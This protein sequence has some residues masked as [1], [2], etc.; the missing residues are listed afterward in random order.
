MSDDVADKVAYKL[1]NGCV[2]NE[3][4]SPVIRANEPR[5]PYCA[6]YRYSRNLTNRR[7]VILAKRWINLGKSKPRAEITCLG[8]VRILEYPKTD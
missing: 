5:T 2:E 7:H 3:V 8:F 4:H 1:G 6:D